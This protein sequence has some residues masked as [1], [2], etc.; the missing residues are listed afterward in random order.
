ML[1]VRAVHESDVID[2][3]LYGVAH[4]DERRA[5]A[6]HEP[7]QQLVDRLGLLDVVLERK[8]A[9]EPLKQLIAQ[10]FV[11]GALIDRDLAAR[12]DSVVLNR[13]GMY[14][15]RLGFAETDLIG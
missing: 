15:R 14:G 5:L 1:R 11:S 9:E 2:G 4:V 12:R 3:P 10:G 7:E 8:R 6:A 13:K